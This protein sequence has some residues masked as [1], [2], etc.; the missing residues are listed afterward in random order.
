MKKLDINL[1]GAYQGKTIEQRYNEK[2]TDFIAN[3]RRY[4][5]GHSTGFFGWKDGYYEKTPQIGEA[6]WNKVYPGGIESFK[7][8]FMKLNSVGQQNVI[9]KI[10]EI[11]DALNKEKQK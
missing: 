4:V 6:E 1:F 9:D 2:R 8:D 10:N 11:I 7:I 3:S 5:P